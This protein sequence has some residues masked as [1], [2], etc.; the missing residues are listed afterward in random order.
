MTVQEL[1]DW[2]NRL[3]REAKGK[4]VYYQRSPAAEPHE[5]GHVDYDLTIVALRQ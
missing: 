1:I 5:I 2:L 3:P 4:P